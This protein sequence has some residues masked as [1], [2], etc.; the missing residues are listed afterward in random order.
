MS[1]NKI[2]Y[3][4]EK[5]SNPWVSNKNVEGSSDRA[6]HAIGIKC[7]LLTIDSFVVLSEIH[8]RGIPFSSESFPP[9]YPLRERWPWKQMVPIRPSGRTKLIS[10]SPKRRADYLSLITGA[11]FPFSL[12][13]YLSFSPCFRKISFIICYHSYPYSPRERE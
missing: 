4:T 8:P 12:C 1:P 11:G 7:L 6:K 13:L 5:Y 3:P 9:R 2:S 10:L